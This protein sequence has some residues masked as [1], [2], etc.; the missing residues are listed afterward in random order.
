MLVGRQVFVSSRKL[1]EDLFPR[2]SP[3]SITQL[4][5]SEIILADRN[6]QMERK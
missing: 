5:M 1:L 4:K 6:P 3:D 2:G